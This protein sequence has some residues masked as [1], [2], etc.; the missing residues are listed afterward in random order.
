VLS[1]IALPGDLRRVLGRIE[2]GELTV[3]A[4]GVSEG[5]DRLYAAVHQLIWAI[6]GSAAGAIAYLADGRGEAGV[7]RL[8]GGVAAAAGVLLVLSLWRAS[9]RKSR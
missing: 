9:W 8:A 4:A 3:R 6:V 5:L 2:R 1:A 7:A